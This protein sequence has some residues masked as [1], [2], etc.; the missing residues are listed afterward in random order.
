MNIYGQK[1]RQEARTVYFADKTVQ[2]HINSCHL[3]CT[4]P[5]KDF[6]GPSAGPI[7]YP[8]SRVIEEVREHIRAEQPEEGAKDSNA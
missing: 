8:Y 1:I 2:T 6:Q 7:L 3:I 5:E 4:G